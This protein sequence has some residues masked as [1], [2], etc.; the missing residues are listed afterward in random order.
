MISKLYIQLFYHRKDVDTIGPEKKVERKIRE[1][2]SSKGGYSLKYH[3][4]GESI[5]GIPDL[6][7]MYQGQTIFIEVKAPN[8]FKLSTIQKAQMRQI[9]RMGGI[10]IATNTVEDVEDVMHFI[11]MKLRGKETDLEVMRCWCNEIGL[12]I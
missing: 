7:C 1:L 2:I 11:D 12:E 4:S 10:A 5:A 3:G 8:H 9:R 6:I